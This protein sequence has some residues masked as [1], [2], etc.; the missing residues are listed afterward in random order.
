VVKRDQDNVAL[1]LKEV[2]RVLGLTQEAL[3]HKIGVS[4]TSVNRWENDQTRP[5]PLA[6]RQIDNLFEHIKR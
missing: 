4:F 5:S 1:K 3:A 2:R 6:K